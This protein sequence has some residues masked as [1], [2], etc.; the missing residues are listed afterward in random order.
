MEHGMPSPTN[1]FGG[2]LIA[3]ERGCNPPP[4][5]RHGQALVT[6]DNGDSWYADLARIKAY[7]VG[8][9]DGLNLHKCYIIRRDGAPMEADLVPSTDYEHTA[10]NAIV[11]F[12]ILNPKIDGMGDLYFGS[13]L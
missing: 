12:F 2:M 8:H 13:H 7:H 1:A 3:L 9:D 10:H 11:S 6:L 4:A 5:L